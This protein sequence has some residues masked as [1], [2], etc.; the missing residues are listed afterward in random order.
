V[1]VVVDLLVAVVI[2]ITT[3]TVDLVVDIVLFL[4]KQLLDVSTASVLDVVVM[5][6]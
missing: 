6:T 4:F 5:K 1:A 2:A 3:V